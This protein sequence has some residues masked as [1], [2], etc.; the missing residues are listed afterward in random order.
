MS[1]DNDAIIIESIRSAVTDA[2]SRRSKSIE[3]ELNIELQ[4]LTQTE[5]ELKAGR[6]RI[7]EIKTLIE[8]E[9]SSVGEFKIKISSENN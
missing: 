6:N 4:T 3:T 8:S 2:I 5:V 1:Q 9:K 7:Q